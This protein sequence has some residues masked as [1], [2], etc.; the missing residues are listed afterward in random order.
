M[1]ENLLKII[2]DV[3]AHLKVPTVLIGG[4]ALPAYNIA[5]TTLDID[6]CIKIESQENLNRFVRAMN[7]KDIRTIQNPKIS[8][9][10]FTVFGK[11][12]EAEIWLKPCDAFHWDDQMLEKIQK[13][14]ANVYV[15]AVEDYIL[16]KLARSDRSSIDIS[17]ILKILIANKNTI[18][19]EYLHFRLKWMDL[20]S[21]FEQIL[22]GFKL[23][24]NNNVRNI[25]K[26]I[27][28]KFK[29]LN[30]SNIEKFKKS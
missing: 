14:F 12:G 27:L 5:R 16:T 7:Q 18:D 20:K 24:F 6:I 2:L 29:K 26:E 9:E 19:W 13:F 11:F 30:A 3:A 10:L 1:I 23:D 4:L 21:D 8:H 17:D 25:S 15:L 28:D 22:E